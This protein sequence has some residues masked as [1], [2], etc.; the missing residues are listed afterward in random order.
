MEAIGFQWCL[1]RNRRGSPSVMSIIVRHK[2]GRGRV[3][4]A[5]LSQVN[6]TRKEGNEKKCASLLSRLDYWY[7]SGCSVRNNP[8]RDPF[9]SPSPAYVVYIEQVIV[10]LWWYRTSPG[11]Y[12]YIHPDFHAPMRRA[13]PKKRI[14]S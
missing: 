1:Y 9:C 3:R 8:P 12:T 2:R 13:R 4:V 5:S 7:I 11:P 14:P 6:L 10:R